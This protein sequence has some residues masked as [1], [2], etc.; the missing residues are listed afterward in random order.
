[1]RARLFAA[2]LVATAIRD[3]AGYEIRARLYGPS[4]P[5]AIG[6]IERWSRRAWRWLRL[7]VRVDGRRPEGPCVYVANHRSY[8]DIPVLAGVLGAPFMS[9]ADVA[10]WPIIGTVARAA[11]CVFVE[12]DDPRARIRAARALA[13]RLRTA[14][15][16]VFPEGTTSGQR[17]PGV[18][19][20]GLFRLLHR[21]G[22][23]V[24]PVTI[25]YGHPRAYWID[26]VTLRDHLL[27]QVQAASRLATAVHIGAPLDVRTHSDGRSL[28]D[29]AWAAVSRP[30]EELGEL[31]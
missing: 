25:R 18:F 2:A 29:A 12:R 13:R 15:V 16:V 1:M 17:L 7:D 21:L 9:R 11:E 30:I 8:L 10:G 28:A 20:A 31:A 26:E 19:H 6:V 4:P 22:I 23:T 14:S 27:R 3:L 24:V 5:R